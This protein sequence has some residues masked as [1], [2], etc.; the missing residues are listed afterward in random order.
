MIN[1]I[2]TNKSPVKK[3]IK[4]VLL[5]LLA[6]IILFLLIS[7][8]YLVTNPI[9]DK[10]DH[11]KFTKL[12]TQMQE[13]F[14]GLKATSNGVDDWKYKAVCSA[15]RSGWMK[16]G[17]YHC[18]TSISTQETVTSV[19]EIND[20]QAKYYP[21]INSSDTLKQKTELDPEMPNDFGKNFVVSSAEKHYTEVKS[22][23]LCQYLFELNQA[24]ENP[25][26]F[27][28]SSEINGKT[29]VAI[30]SLRCE[31]IARGQW[32]GLVQTTSMLI[33]E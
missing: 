31:E 16:T 9:L 11:D 19:Q 28:Y 27:T 8:W 5:I 21:V 14:Q 13:V 20:L 26:N 1:N 22:G 6:P 23:I 32:Y 30:I 3:I 33:P 18:V 24:N 4:V 17:K 15:D 7:L 25:E 2:N 12:D 10:L 29:G